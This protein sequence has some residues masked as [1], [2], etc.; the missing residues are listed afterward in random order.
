MSP[1]T[2]VDVLKSVTSGGA[3]KETT[4]LTGLVTEIDTGVENVDSAD[5]VT[6][7]NTVDDGVDER[8]ETTAV[9]VEAA[10]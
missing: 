7:L 4:P 9:V 2:P 6:V 1:S 10:L 3:V 5:E 8:K